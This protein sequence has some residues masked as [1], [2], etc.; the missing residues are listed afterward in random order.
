MWSAATA[1]EVDSSPA[2]ADGVVYVG[3][4]DR[5]LYAFDAATGEEVWR[6]A[7]GGFIISSPAVANGVVYVGSRDRYLYAYGLPQP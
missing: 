6:V 3:S 1:G 7:T 2:V 5:Y 4:T